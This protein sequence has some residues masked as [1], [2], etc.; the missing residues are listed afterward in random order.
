LAFSPTPL[1]KLHHFISICWMQNA[2]LLL[3]TALYCCIQQANA[4]LV[5]GRRSSFSNDQ[6]LLF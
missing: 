6:M 1:T 3:P 4:S 5:F 2:Y